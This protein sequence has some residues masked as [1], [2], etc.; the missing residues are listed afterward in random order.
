MIRLLTTWPYVLVLFFVVAAMAKEF[1]SA[2]NCTCFKG[3]GGGEEK[4]RP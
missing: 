1:G 3:G 2:R 4:K